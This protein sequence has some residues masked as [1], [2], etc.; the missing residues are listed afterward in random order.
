MNMNGCRRL[1]FQHGERVLPHKCPKRLIAF[2][3]FVKSILEW[4]RS[5][6]P[7]CTGVTTAT[8][9]REVR[10]RRSSLEVQI[11]A[12]APCRPSHRCDFDRSSI[13]KSEDARAQMWLFVRLKTVAMEGVNTDLE[14]YL[15]RHYQRRSPNALAFTS[16]CC[17][18]FLHVK[19][20]TRLQAVSASRPSMRL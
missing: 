20:W 14:Y 1:L 9:R 18:N 19:L 11:K 10:Y 8:A 3:D 13:T 16:L 15:T 4:L 2:S 17:W 12:P 7:S 6:S 5:N